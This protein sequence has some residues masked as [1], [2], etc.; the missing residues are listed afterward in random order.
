MLLWITYPTVTQCSLGNIRNLRSKDKPVKYRPTSAG[1]LDLLLHDSFRC[2]ASVLWRN[3]QHKRN[4]SWL[5]FVSN[6]CHFRFL[7]HT[8]NVSFWT[9]IFYLRHKNSRTTVLKLLLFYCLDNGNESWNSLWI[10]ALSVS[11]IT[12]FEFSFPGGSIGFFHSH[13][14]CS[15]NSPTS[16][17][18]VAS[19]HS[20]PANTKSENAWS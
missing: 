6:I 7:W 11:T 17:L 5:H 9:W 8:D 3:G 18:P 4:M 15:C 20:T 16:F 2:R 1:A 14:P 13:D 10:C 19:A 12:I